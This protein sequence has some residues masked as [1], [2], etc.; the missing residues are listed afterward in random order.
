[1]VLR[2]FA[3][4]R[5]IILCIQKFIMHEHPW[6]HIQ[7]SCISTYQLTCPKELKVA[8]VSGF[9]WGI[10]PVSL[11]LMLC[12]RQPHKFYEV[13]FSLCSISNWVNGCGLVF[14]KSIFTLILLY[15][16]TVIEHC[17]LGKQCDNQ[18]VC[19]FEVKHWFVICRVFLL[20][21]K[22]SYFLIMSC[23]GVVHFQSSQKHLFKHSAHCSQGNS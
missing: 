19:E 3:K 17:V 23:L 13:V 7:C 14:F 8:D 21:K 15:S 22:S 11:S 2:R 5:T 12:P 9:L 18:L 16:A 1:M 20:I 6:F 4:E 10:S